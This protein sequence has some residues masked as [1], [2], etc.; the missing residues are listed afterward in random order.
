MSLTVS[1]K[2]TALVTCFGMKRFTTN[3]VM[4]VLLRANVPTEEVETEAV[5]LVQEWKNKDMTREL[6]P[7]VWLKR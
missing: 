3:D 1:Q 7:N 5:N 4:A 2:N 6:A